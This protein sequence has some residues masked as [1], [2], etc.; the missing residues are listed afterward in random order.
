MR[1]K[2]GQQYSIKWIDAFGDSAWTDDKEREKLVTQFEKP[3][4]QTFYFIKQTDEFYVFTSGKPEAGKPYI[5][6]HGIPKVWAVELKPT[7]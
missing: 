2:F 1:P 5:D 4:D 6:I 7:R 3:A